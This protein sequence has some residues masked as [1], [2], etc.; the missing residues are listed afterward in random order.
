MRL[1]GRFWAPKT[2][3]KSDENQKSQSKNNIEIDLLFLLEFWSCWSPKWKPRT[4]IFLPKSFVL[5]YQSDLPLFRP[6]AVFGSIL[7]PTWLDF[8]T[9]LEA[10]WENIGA[11]TDLKKLPIL[12]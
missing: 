2:V 3:P 1:W 10:K 8:G 4:S 7:V 12:V 5:Q 6:D 9:I 11:R